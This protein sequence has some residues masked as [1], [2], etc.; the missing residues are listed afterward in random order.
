MSRKDYKHLEAFGVG[1]ICGALCEDTGEWPLVAGVC[2]GGGARV[3][4]C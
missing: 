1:G 3:C 4:V 2:V